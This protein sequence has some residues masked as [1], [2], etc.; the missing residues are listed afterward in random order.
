MF[1]FFDFGK[2]NF[3]ATRNIH[4]AE[5]FYLEFIFQKMIFL[6]EFFKNFLRIFK[7]FLDVQTI[8]FH[9]I[10][11]RNYKLQKSRL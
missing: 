7:E 10:K 11:N 8:Q 5:S 6:E 9:Q 3:H 2:L 4:Q 1:M